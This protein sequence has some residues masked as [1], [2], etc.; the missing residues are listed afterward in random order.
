M[1]ALSPHTTKIGMTLLPLG[2]PLTLSPYQLG[3]LLLFNI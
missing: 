3:N 2:I 1:E